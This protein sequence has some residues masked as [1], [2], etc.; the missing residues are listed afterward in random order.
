[1]LCFSLSASVSTILTQI[2]K[3]YMFIFGIYEVHL[4]LRSKFQ[5]DITIGFEM[6]AILNTFRAFI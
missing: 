5:N 3:K 2:L 6:V 1:M 4:I